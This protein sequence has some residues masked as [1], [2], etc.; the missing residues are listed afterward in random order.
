[1]GYVFIS[2]SSTQSYQM[3]KMTEFLKTN[4]ISFWVA[5][6]DIP[7]GAK[8]SEVIKR[9]IEESSCVLFLLSDRSQNS[10]YCKLEIALAVQL[11][12]T[13]IPVQLEDL[14][15]NDAFSLYLST[16]EIY[17]F[18]GRIT[19]AGT[20]QLLNQLNLLCGVPSEQKLLDPSYKIGKF[21]KGTWL[22]ILGWLWIVFGGMLISMLTSA[23]FPVPP[24]FDS[25]TGD[26]MDSFL[27]PLIAEMTISGDILGTV[28][29]LG[30]WMTVFYGF[31]LNRKYYERKYLFFKQ[32]SLCQMLLLFFIVGMGIS[33]NLNT[34][35][36][37]N[38]LHYYYSNFWVEVTPVIYDTSLCVLMAALV[39]WLFGRIRWVYQ[40]R[41]SKKQKQNNGII[42]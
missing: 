30:G 1:M 33:W 17:P 37:I 9:A 36:V 2:Y 4:G 19:T 18:P 26:S 23:L 34:Y 35:R 31:T 10:T 22:Q 27:A 24:L 20:V 38:H 11:E 28:L 16:S 29:R 14:I 3:K 8:Y 41:K 39:I 25:F 12:K 32:F 42:A 6:D 13:I 40:L 5:P 21:R 15:L 7:I